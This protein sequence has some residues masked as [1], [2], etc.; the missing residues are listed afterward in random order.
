MAKNPPGKPKSSKPEPSFPK[1]FLGHVFSLLR[2]HGSTIALWLGLGYIA[3]PSSLAVIQYAGRTSV[4]DLSVSMMANISLD[5]ESNDDRLVNYLI[6][7]G[8]EPSPKDAGEAGRS[9]CRIGIEA[10]SIPDV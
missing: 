3:R 2:R 1:W 4:A 6:L 10:R 9:G 5:G 7:K 8:E